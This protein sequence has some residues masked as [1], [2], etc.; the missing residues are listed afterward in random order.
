[1]IVQP[2]GLIGVLLDKTARED[3]RDDAAMDLGSYPTKE[4]LEALFKVAI[5]T[6]ENDIILD[7]CGESLGEI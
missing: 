1:M 7:S 6:T 3:E 5:D 4:A 2:E